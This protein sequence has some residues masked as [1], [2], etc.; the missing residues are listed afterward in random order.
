MN[1]AWE[2]DDIVHTAVAIAMTRGSPGAVRAL[3]R[4]GADVNIGAPIAYMVSLYD[5]AMPERL[6]EVLQAPALELD[7]VARNDRGEEVGLLDLIWDNPEVDLQDMARAM[8]NRV[9]AFH[10]Q[11]MKLLSPHPAHSLQ[12]PQ[13]LLLSPVPF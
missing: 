11:L 5:W 13:S 9:G 2:D 3:I 1:L 7:I 12:V 6:R 4:A 8:L 10:I